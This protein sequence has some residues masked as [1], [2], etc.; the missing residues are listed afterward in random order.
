MKTIHISTAKLLWFEKKNKKVNS[1]EMIF[2]LSKK[3]FTDFYF[4]N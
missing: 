1:F 4:F 2:F 3:I